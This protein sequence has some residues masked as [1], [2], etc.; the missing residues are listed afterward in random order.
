MTRE[1]F[2]GIDIGTYESKG[3][4]VDGAGRIVARGTVPHGVSMPKPGWAEHDADGIWWGDFCRLSQTLLAGSDIQ[5]SDI[6]AV[7]CSTIAPCTLPVDVHGTPLRPAILYGIDT[8]AGAQIAALENELGADRILQVG[9]NV[10]SA[11]SV[12]PKIRWLRENEP[13]LFDKAWKFMTGTSYLV[14]RLTG[15]CVIDFYTSLTFSPMFNIN[16]LRWDEDMSRPVVELSRLPDQRWTSEVVGR[17]TRAAAAATGL[18]EGTPVITG[19]ADAAAEAVSV[20]VVSPGQM[21]LMYGST[22]FFIEITEGLVIDKR[23]WTGVYLFPGTYALLGGMATSGSVTRWFRDNFAHAEL[24][25]EEETGINAYAQLA[26]AASEIPAGAEGLLVLPYF[27]GERTPLNDP[28]ARGVVA[29]LTLSHTRAHLYR[30][31]LEGTAYGVR[32][33]LEIMNELGYRPDD[34]VAVG[35]GTRNN[36]WMQIVSDVGY[37]TQRVPAGTFGASYGDAFLAAYGVG[38]VRHYTD[39]SQWVDK[40]IRVEPDSVRYRLYS[41]YYDLYRELYE[42]SAATIHKLAQIGLG[43]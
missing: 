14:F 20:G 23:L 2:L 39:I 7:G 36:L 25:Q 40:G 27:S 6:A 10:L 18:L 16:E 1:Y 28:L 5:A 12:G 26:A 19:T 42:V 41:K 43:G 3:V 35:G 22:M 4:I 38:A 34:V 17:V 9:G 21:M 8:R 30:A 31:I 33:H 37:I 11:Q 15:E 32:H 13:D 24:R 29:G